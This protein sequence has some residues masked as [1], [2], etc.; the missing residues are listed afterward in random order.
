MQDLLQGVSLQR[1]ASWREEGQLVRRKEG[2]R[3]K[4]QCQIQLQIS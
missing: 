4:W 2:G 1:R 3:L